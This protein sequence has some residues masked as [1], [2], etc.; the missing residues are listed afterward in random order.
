MASFSQPKH[1]TKSPQPKHLARRLRLAISTVLFLYL[2]LAA[3]NDI[4]DF[5]LGGPYCA[6]FSLARPVC[7]HS[8]PSIK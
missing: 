8:T 1:L 5:F 3:A 7:Q 6:W 2:G 4:K